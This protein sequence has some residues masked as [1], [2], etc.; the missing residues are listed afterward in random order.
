MNEITTIGTQ[1][2]RNAILEL[3]RKRSLQASSFLSLLALSACG[4]GS[5][6]S[7]DGEGS[8]STPGVSYTG[9]VIKGPLENALV[10]LDYDGDGVFGSD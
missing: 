8:S 10:F 9:S 7:T 5:G 1:R 4:G 3:K 2:F 6:S